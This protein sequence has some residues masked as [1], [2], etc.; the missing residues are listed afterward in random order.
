MDTVPLWALVAA[1]IFLFIGSAFF[2][3]AETA[4]MS[5][6]KYRLRNLAK[7]GHRGAITTLWLLDRTDKL[8]S[9][10]L[11]ANTLINTAATALAT[12]IAILSF[13]YQESAIAI[14][15]IGVAF[16]LIVFAE[17]T[18]KFIGAAYPETISLVASNLLR[19]LMTVAK[20]L[21]WFVNI[22]VG[23]VLK[24]MRARP[25]PGTQPHRVSPEELR[26]IVLEGGNFIP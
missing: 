14:A 20:P 16:A 25:E 17:I 26:A 4:L 15:I 22:F 7:R 6:N 19:P 24:L 3:M 10:I 21:I 8:L 9:L 13:G 2:A 18:P 5:A 11:I 12:A 23:M 1:L